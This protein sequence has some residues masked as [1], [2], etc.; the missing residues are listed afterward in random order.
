MKES[1]FRLTV[2]NLNLADWQA[3]L[4]TNP[5]SGVVNVG[6]V[7][8]AQDNGKKLGL[9]VNCLVDKFAMPVGTLGAGTASGTAAY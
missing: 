4:G 3:M 6:L 9:D 2:T 8:V 1:A 5:P 7:A